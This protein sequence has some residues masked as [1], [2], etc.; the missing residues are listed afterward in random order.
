M[1]AE[2]IK[3][4]ICS[5]GYRRTNQKKRKKFAF[6]LVQTFLDA[7]TDCDFRKKSQSKVQGFT[8]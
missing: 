7:N 6:L 4:L 8:G 1:S 2:Q 3:K 5:D